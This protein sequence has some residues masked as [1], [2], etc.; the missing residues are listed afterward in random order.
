[1]KKLDSSSMQKKCIEVAELLKSLSH[2]QR[3][4]MT[5]YLS[6]GEKTVGELQE[7]CDISQ[8]QLSQFLARLSREGIVSS[9][10]E[11]QYSYYA[12]KSKDVLKMLESMQKIFC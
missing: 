10:R 4:M 11:G 12:I 8:S 2:P 9:R 1:M 3:L 6:E 5:C 7:L